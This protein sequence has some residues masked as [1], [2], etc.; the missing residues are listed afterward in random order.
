MFRSFLTNLSPY[1]LIIKAVSIISFIVA[2]STI[3][4]VH[5][6][7]D[8]SVRKDL[9]KANLLNVSREIQIKA[10]TDSR[11]AEIEAATK[12]AAV[13][14][15]KANEEKKAALTALGLE[16]INRLEL[17]KRI[18]AINEADNRK[19]ADTKFNYNERLRLEGVNSASAISQESERYA[20]LPRSAPECDRAIAE[21]DTLKQA[22]QLTT[23]DFNA[24]RLA[25]DA[26]TAACGREK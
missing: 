8:A 11:K 7:H 18:E 3:V 25:Y 17:M 14:T 13:I 1:F 9:K 5:F 4:G 15:N 22:C 16:H 6:Y 10:L 2:L 26:D 12:A 23:I 24:C 19:L 20:Q 21:Y